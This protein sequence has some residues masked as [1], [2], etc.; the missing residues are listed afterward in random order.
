MELRRNLPVGLHQRP[1]NVRTRGVNGDPQTGKL[2]QSD[3]GMIVRSQFIARLERRVERASRLRRESIGNALLLP[4]REAH[5]PGREAQPCP[6]EYQA[7]L[8]RARTKR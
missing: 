7:G 4:R 2:R 1:P 3:G 5:Q 8:A 6:L